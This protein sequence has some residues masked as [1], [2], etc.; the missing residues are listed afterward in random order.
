MNFLS[1]ALPHLDR[2]YVAAG[3]AVPDWLSV[4][5]RRVRAR[6]VL[7]RPLLE[8]PDPAVR[9]I[10]EGV[11]RHH[12]DD[13]WFHASQAF[14]ELNLTFALE[15]RGLLAGDEGF[16]PSFLGHILV[17]ILLDA[18]LIA[19]DRSRADAYYAAL[20]ELSPELVQATVNRLAA[21]PTDRL[22]ELLPRFIAERFL[23]DY[24]SNDRLLMRLNQV[25]RRV[26]LPMLPETLLPWLDSARERVASRRG[27]LLQPP[28]DRA[29][30]PRPF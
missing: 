13:R 18:D 16:R 9:C 2:P 4:V 29:G 15:L 20:S 7:A 5:D 19:E 11:I 25:M 23:Y 21:R 6:S 22:A 3:T 28:T 1:H 27:E 26:R 8:D 12:E 24:A 10:A 14:A 17:E 30:L